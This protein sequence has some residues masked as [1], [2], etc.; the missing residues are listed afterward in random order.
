VNST[1]LWNTVTFHVNKLLAAL[2]FK[3]NVN[4]IFRR[5]MA[6][7]S[8]KRSKEGEPLDGNGRETKKLKSRFEDGPEDKDD[9]QSSQLTSSQIKEMMANAQ[10][11]IEERK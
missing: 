8:L 6:T 1:L 9:S 10:R 4:F 3:I 2:N 11:M 5:E 7:V